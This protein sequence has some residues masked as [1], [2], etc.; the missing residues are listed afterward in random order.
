MPKLGF[1]YI[2]TNKNNTVLYT[3]TS[4]ELKD[5]V[6]KH[7][8]KFYQKSFTAKYNINKLVYFEIHADMESAI[9]REK[10]IKGGSRLKKVVLIEK[11][12]PERKDLYFDLP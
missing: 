6:K 1:T 5:R 9:K 8:D 4:S 2:M 10:Q 11:S 3:G 12:N 7:K